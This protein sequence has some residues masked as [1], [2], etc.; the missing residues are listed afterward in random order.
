MNKQILNPFINNFFAFL[1]I[2]NA[3]IDPANELFHFKVVSFFLFLLFSINKIGFPIK[4]ILFFSGIYFI[5]FLSSSI[6][7][8]SDN[9]YDMS[10]FLNYS[11]TFI[12][13]LLLFYGKAIDF[14]K[15]YVFASIVISLVTII[16]SVFF[17]FF[18]EASIIISTLPSSK[19]IFQ[20]AFSKKV[21][22][23]DF[24]SVFHKSAPI[25]VIPFSFF[26]DQYL[27]KKKIKYLSLSILIGLA[28]FFSGTRANILSL[29]LIFFLVSLFFLYKVKQKLLTTVLLFLFVSFFSFLAIY[30]LFT[31]KNTSS[32]AKDGHLL[33]YIEL[34]AEKPSIILFGQGP[35]SLFFSKGFNKFTP[36]TEL[37]Y[38]ELIRMFGIFSTFFFISFYFYPLLVLLRSRK[39]YSIG[40]GY[41]AYLFIAGTNPFLFGPQGFISLVI[42]YQFACS[43]NKRGIRFD[44]F[45][46]NCNIQS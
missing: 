19:A 26:W 6:M 14:F 21:L 7:I 38:L 39:L 4:F 34:F 17:I 13:L 27:R 15:Y 41:L 11:T 24:I 36:N 3:L 30:L 29:F 37:T 40:I 10:F 9:K 25:L 35:G 20:L 45:S 43:V 16:I 46:N 23:W 33:S 28:L 44:N 31:V 5:L 8:L 22:F 1:F 42:S 2:L 12:T 18:P 32:V